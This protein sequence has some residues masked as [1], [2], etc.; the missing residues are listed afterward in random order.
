MPKSLWGWNKPKVTD[1]SVTPTHSGL[2]PQRG[3]KEAEVE[4]GK[5]TGVRV[6]KAGPATVCPW[7]PPFRRSRKVRKE[8]G[9]TNPLGNRERLAASQ[10]SWLQAAWEAHVPFTLSPFPCYWWY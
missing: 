4:L 5:G 9:H 2:P 8:L 6:E 7:G 3:F 1:V 10:A